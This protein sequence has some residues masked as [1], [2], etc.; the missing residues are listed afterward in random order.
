MR[1]NGKRIS[2]FGTILNAPLGKYK[3]VI[4]DKFSGEDGVWKIYDDKNESIKDAIK[5][6]REASKYSSHH[7]V[8]TVFYAYDDQGNYLGG[9]IH[10]ESLDELLDELVEA[11]KFEQPK[12]HKY[13]K[14]VRKELK[15]LRDE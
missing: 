10:E 3:V 6:T 7:S 2:P 12:Y 13:L 15:A 14:N 8:A 5:L 1:K 9:D 4:V 11:M